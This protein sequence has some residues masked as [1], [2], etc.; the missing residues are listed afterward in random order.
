MQNTDTANGQR[1]LRLLALGT[2]IILVQFRSLNGSLDDGGIRGLSEL[3]IL[4][5]IMSQLKSLGKMESTPKPCE[6]FDVIGGAGTGGI[7]ALMLGRLQMP[8]DVA[9][10]KY[11][12]FS[13]KVYSDVKKFKFGKSGPEKFRATTFVSEM[14]HILT[15]AG[16]SDN[17]LM[18]EEDPICR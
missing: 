12:D 10:D 13:R 14:K 11:V 17:L 3:I 16:F 4:Q 7:I 5:E 18:L 2:L 6:F 9:I 15:S 8:I 1:G